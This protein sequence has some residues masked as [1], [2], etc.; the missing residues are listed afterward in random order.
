MRMYL[1][2]SS[3]RRTKSKNLECALSR[4][5]IVFAQSIDAMCYV[6]NEDV[7]EA[8]PAG[9]APIT[10]EWSTSLFTSKVRLTWEV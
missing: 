5:A 4:L 8:A 9:D 10:S 1:Q 6:E 2:T 3:L 7:A